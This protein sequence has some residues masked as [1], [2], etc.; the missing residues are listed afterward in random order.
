GA[1]MPGGSFRFQGG[2]KKPYFM[3]S[4][5]SYYRTVFDNVY[6]RLS[7]SK[8]IEM[9]LV[10][11][12]CALHG[13]DI[14]MSSTEVRQF[15]SLAEEVRSADL[16]YQEQVKMRDEMKDWKYKPKEYDLGGESWSFKIDSGVMAYFE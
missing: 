1:S 6:S 9:G 4:V 8:S 13:V 5:P 7:S 12:S 10:I 3:K 16:G 15:I 14:L 2:E 11:S